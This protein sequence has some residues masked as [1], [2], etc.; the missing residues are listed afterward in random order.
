MLQTPEDIKEEI[1]AEQRLE[2]LSDED[3]IK[4][5]N[6]IELV[7]EAFLEFPCEG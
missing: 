4:K 6:D 7:K 1:I 3:K 5:H 2:G